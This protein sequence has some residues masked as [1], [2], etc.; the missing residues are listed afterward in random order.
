VQ[1]KRLSFPPIKQ[2]GG[3]T[4][5]LLGVDGAAGEDVGPEMKRLSAMNLM[6][7]NVKFSN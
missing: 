6:S 4:F 2:I 5:Q 7:T 1:L 3:E